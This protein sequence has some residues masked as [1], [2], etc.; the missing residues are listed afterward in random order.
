MK[1]KF[2]NTIILLIIFSI[3]QYNVLSLEQSRLEIGAD[4]INNAGITGKGFSICLLDDGV[5]YTHPNLGGCNISQISSGICPTFI[6]ATD[7][8]DKD[9]DPFPEGTQTHGTKIA[10]IILS[11]HSK[12][13]GIAPLAKISFVRIFNFDFVNNRSFTNNSVILDGIHWCIDNKD[14]YNISVISLSMGMGFEQNQSVSIQ[15][16]EIINDARKNGI[17]FVKSSGNR[18]EGESYNMTFPAELG[19]V[20]SVG[21]NTKDSISYFTRRESNLD[22]LAPGDRIRTT[23]TGGDFTSYIGNYVCWHNSDEYLG[24]NIIQILFPFCNY[25][26]SFSAPHV[27]AS[28]ILLKQYDT[29]LKPF[30]IE[31]ILKENGDEI[32]DLITNE[33]IIR[34]NL[35]KSFHI[36][37][38]PTENHDYRR[39]GFT[40]LKGDITN[41]TIKSKTNFYLDSAN[42]TEQVIKPSVGDLDNNGLMD[43]VTLVHKTGFSNYTKMIGVENEQ[44]T[45]LGIPLPEKVNKWTQTY[46]IQGGAIYFPPT[47][48]DIDDDGEREIITGT[49]N[50]TIYAFDYDKDTRTAN[51]KWAYYLEERYSALTGIDEVYF[52]GGTAVTDI[53]LD[54][55]QEIIFADVSSS[56]L[57]SSW[58]G[59]VYI[60]DG[61]SG[62]LETSYTVGNG[63]TYATISI[64]NVDNDDYPEIIVP[65]RYG[66]KVLDYSNGN[67]S[68]KCQTLHGLIEGS[69]VIYDVERDNVYE[70]VYVTNEGV[71]DG[72]A[73]GKTCYNKLYIINAIN[74]STEL[75]QSISALPRPTPTIA[76]LD[77]DSQAEIVISVVN[78]EYNPST[79]KGNISAIDSST[80]TIQWTYD[81][82]GTL[83]PGFVSPN[84][85]DIDN[86]GEYNIILGENDGSTVY[87]LNNNGTK[88]FDYSI[89]G[90]MDNGIAVADVDNDKTAEIVF[91]RAGSPQTILVSVSA[92]NNQP[93]ITK[94]ENLTAIAGEKIKIKGIESSDLDGTSLTHSY[95]SPF[96]ESGEWQTTINDTG[97]YSIIIEVSDGNLTDYKYIEAKVFNTTA[98][99][100]DNFSDGTKNKLFNFTQAGNISIKIRIQKN[101]TILYSKLKIKGLPP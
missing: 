19:N 44:R 88:L 11:N 45:F 37:D 61:D 70:L 86:D 64:A 12:F 95:G 56:I 6:A 49:R 60:L 98:N 41:S 82:A 85:A 8:S 75:E 43:V 76:N 22:L 9:A 77:S 3:C 101:S 25:G 55:Q 39:T 66:I 34:I 71:L 14:N 16:Q 10:G 90:Y 42:G 46:D 54:G 79:A 2:Y 50:G 30:D 29:A 84:I 57:D 65:T 100:I 47:L 87:V 23:K 94:T 27:S 7:I 48:A 81:A 96:N 1:N 51:I 97:N 93:M 58:S 24:S 89:L 33:T 80:G 72:C 17:L 4:I 62:N 36:L 83:H 73:S 92:G 15:F 20:T 67:L 68:L 52:N 59:K 91:K 21:S 28:A 13:K 69:A 32:F 38:W 63:G 18:E 53:D 5:D 31:Q 40:L 74:C 26:T 99:R 78:D 35:Y